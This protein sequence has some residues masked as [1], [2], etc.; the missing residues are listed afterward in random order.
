[1]DYDEREIQA[2][3]PDKFVCSD[4]FDDDHLKAFIDDT[5]ENRR[6]SYCGKLSRSKNIAAPIDE[7]IERIFSAISSRYGEA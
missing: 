1:M 5:V 2:S 4:C 3:Y 7:V 6:C